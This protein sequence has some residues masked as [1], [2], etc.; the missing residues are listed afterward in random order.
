MAKP[1][2]AVLG[3][4]YM[5]AFAILGPGI[6]VCA[7]LASETVPVG[8]IALARF[9]VQAAAFGAVLLLLGR[10][11][12]PARTLPAHFLRGALIAGATLFFFSALRVMPVADA[13]AIFFVE[14]L[15]LT[16]LSA[17]LLGEEVGWRRYAGC[18]V[19]LAGALLVIQPSFEAFGAPALFPLGTAVCFAF[20]M[21]LSR[22]LG[23]AGDPLSMQ[24]LAGASGAIVV[25]IALIAGDGSGTAFDPAMPRGS[26]WALLLGVGLFAS[27]AHLMIVQAVRHAPASVVAP[28]QYLEIATA[29]ALGY[30][31]WGDFPDPLKWLGIAIVVGSGLFVLHRERIAARRA[32]EAA[33]PTD[34]EAGFARST[35]GRR[36][37]A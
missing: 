10:P 6:D 14:P 18:A 31:V 3:V 32:R 36:G 17:L 8:V 33:L 35:A 24:A 2:G 22:R 9:V 7:K 21:V 1:E 28:V 23:A 29:A 27:L 4:L 15:I 20:Y 26:D 34:P 19:G 30:L 13:M 5:F 25:G 12:A 16:L 37:A 11:W